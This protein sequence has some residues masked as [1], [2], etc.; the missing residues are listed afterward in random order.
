VHQILSGFQL[1]SCDGRN[2]APLFE[3]NEIRARLVVVVFVYPCRVPG[4]SRAVFV[5]HLAIFF[6]PAAK[7]RRRAIVTASFTGAMG[8]AVYLAP[9]VI[10]DF[11]GVWIRPVRT[12]RTMAASGRPSSRGNLKS[13]LLDGASTISRP[14]DRSPGNREVVGAHN[15]FLKYWPG[16]VAWRYRLLQSAPCP[17]THVSF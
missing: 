11:S 16:Q 1:L 17:R 9:T 13:R 10:S 8:G 12:I 15:T 5:S 7:Q 14:D 2:Q 6:R 3:W 4:G